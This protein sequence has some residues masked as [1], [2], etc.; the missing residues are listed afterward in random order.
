MERGGAEVT[1]QLSFMEKPF[2]FSAYH[3][4]NHL[5]RAQFAVNFERG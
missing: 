3:V 5:S 4:E 2:R 1:N